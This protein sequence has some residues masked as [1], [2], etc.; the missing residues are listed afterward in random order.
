MQSS[1]VRSRLKAQLTKFTAE[2]GEGVSKPLRE[3]VGEMLLGIQASQDVKLSR[4]ARSLQEEIPLIKT[5]GRGIWVI[6]RGGDRKKLLELLLERKERFVIRSTGQ[7]LVTN[8]RGRK[9]AV[10]PLGAC[11]IGRACSRS[12]MGKRRSMSCATGPSR[13]ACRGGKKDFGW[14]P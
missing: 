12:K 8:R 14:W 9:V 3:F 1:K 13:C 4:I 5:E 10:H 7:W 6:D 11:A 2:L